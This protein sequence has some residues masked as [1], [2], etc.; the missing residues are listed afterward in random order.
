[1]A[2]IPNGFEVTVTRGYSTKGPSGVVRTP[3]GGGRPRYALDWDRGSI[4]FNVALVLDMLQWQVW[5]SFYLIVVKK[6]AL[7]FD[8]YL[9]SG[10]GRSLHT[11]N[12]VPGSYSVNLD[13]VKY[14]SVAFTVETE[15]QI[16]LDPDLA[17]ALIDFYNSA[18][19]AANELLSALEYFANTSSDAL[20]F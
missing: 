18:G 1:M 12:I 4:Q 9:D 17:L 11:V 14:A 19:G 7:P 13:L 8:M 15:S 6:G 2:Q 5:E 10:M 3:V 20:D 16:Y